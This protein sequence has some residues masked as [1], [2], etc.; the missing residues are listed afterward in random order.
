VDSDRYECIQT[1]S[2]P[3]TMLVMIKKLHDN[4]DLVGTIEGDVK[5]GNCSISSNIRIW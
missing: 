3:T 4:L 2:K 5:H 1:N